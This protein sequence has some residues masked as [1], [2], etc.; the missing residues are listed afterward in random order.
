MPI[1]RCFGRGFRVPDLDQLFCYETTK[2]V[3][4]LDWKPGVVYRAG[5]VFTCLYCFAFA[6]IINQMYLSHTQAFGSVM[7]TAKGDAWS[8]P[9]VSVEQDSDSGASRRLLNSFPSSS[10]TS[11][12]GGG[13]ESSGASRKILATKAP[14]MAPTA[15][16]TGPRLPQYRYWDVHDTVN[17]DSE[18]GG[19][20]L[21]TR[22]VSTKG[23]SM[24]PCAN[25]LKACPGQCSTDLPIYP[26]LCY[27]ST[28]YC[29]EFNWC[30]LFGQAGEQST[31]DLIQGVDAFEL[32]FMATMTFDVHKPSSVVVKHHKT[33]VKQILKLANLQYSDIQADGVVLHARLQWGTSSEPCSF[34]G[35][36]DLGI[37]V[38]QMDDQD[39]SGF[40]FRQS[41]YYRGNGTLPKEYRDVSRIHAI[42][43]L[44]TS[45]GYATKFS[46][47]DAV[48]QVAS[49]FAMFA[50]SYVIADIFVV[51]LNFRRD[52][53]I[54]LKIEETPDLSDL[55][56]K[57]EAAKIDAQTNK[58]AR[59]P[60]VNRARQPK[61]ESDGSDED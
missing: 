7:I 36:C 38:T 13:V 25:K 46:L 18:S 35:N 1:V 26:G 19:L 51:W 14:T 23:Q 31:E 24:K 20:V 59:R 54:E 12:P 37:Q 22:V 15:A 42:R 8:S 32:D 57:Q 53:Y 50:M 11:A 43:I 47:V 16:D 3:N 52:K 21:A 60:R 29:M 61:P 49:A 48:L 33:T 40:N 44:A 17:P 4:V 5:I 41:T 56:D 30:P 6:L 45:S 9:T 34:D 39:E 28:S 58:Q 10:L 55:K 2:L 27:P